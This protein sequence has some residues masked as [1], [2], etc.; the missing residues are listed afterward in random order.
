MDRFHGNDF[1]KEL[2]YNRAL[3]FIGEVRGGISW[4]RFCMYAIYYSEA[5]ID[6]LKETGGVRKFLSSKDIDRKYVLENSKEIFYRLHFNRDNDHYLTLALPRNATQPQIHKRW[7]D[8]I[9]LYHPDRNRDSGRYMAECAKRIN[10]AYSALKDEVERMKYD[11]KILRP[12]GIY[13][14]NVYKKPR[15][16]ASKRRLFL[17]PHVKRLIPKLITLSYIVVP[18]LI[19]LIIFFENRPQKIR[20]FQ[21]AASHTTHVS[22]N[23]GEE[24]RTGRQYKGEEHSEGMPGVRV[25]ARNNKALVTLVSQTKMKQVETTSQKSHKGF[26]RKAETDMIIGNLETPLPP[27]KQ[28]DH[29]GEKEPQMLMTA[30]DASQPPD[31]T[32]RHDISK[33]VEEEVRFFIIRYILAYERGDIEEFMHFYSESAVENNRLNYEDI[34]KAYKKNFAT[35]VY[36]YGINNVQFQKSGDDIIVTGQYMLSKLNDNNATPI[37]GNIQWVLSRED[38]ALKI[39]KVDYDRR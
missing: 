29:K 25:S 18:L 23:S 14:N 19:L 38:G 35:G 31:E 22:A 36:K 11:R 12:E 37:K 3:E 21:A 39:M 13:S 9:L 32:R 16:V 2:M 6:M 34:R 30:D 28:G 5:F 20:I 15:I 26:F 27:G 7:K 8:L 1:N 4:E 10:G 33:K 17:S 24:L